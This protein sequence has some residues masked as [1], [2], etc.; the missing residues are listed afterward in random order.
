MHLE[1]VYKNT[2]YTDTGYGLITICQISDREVFLFDT[3][4]DRGDELIAL[5]DAQGW[6]VRAAFCTH[7]HHDHIFN[8]RALYERYGTEIWL[9]GSELPTYVTR[10]KID[11]PF[12]LIGNTDIL[13]VAGHEIRV[14]PTPG[15]TPDH[16]IFINPDG[17]GCMGDALISHE[18]LD[19]FKLP[20]IEAVERAIL[21]L[22]EIRSLD[23]PWFV[24]AHRAAVPR[25]QF[26]S[27]ID[28]NIQKELELYELLRCRITQPTTV[29]EAVT[30]FMLSLHISPRRVRE[31]WYLRAT[32]RERIHTLA[33]AGEL[34]LNGD[35]IFPANPHH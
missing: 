28:E 11:Y 6:T 32:V 2:W 8:N 20:Y 10:T 17:V 31:A 35:R 22:E 9:T 12:R 34:I 27:L 19:G 15:H 3:G 4:N 7:L 33:S 25:E 5:L 29:D 13:H 21:S 26:S 16:V 23:C 14:I 30:D 24:L 1:H 18:I